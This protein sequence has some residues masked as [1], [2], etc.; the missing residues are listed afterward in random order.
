L[1]R[2]APN[3]IGIPLWVGLVSVVLWYTARVWR[4]EA[5]V[6][7]RVGTVILASVL[8]NPH[9]IIYDAAVLALPLLWF[10]A[11]MQ[12]PAQSEQATAYGRTV[13]W[14]LAALFVPTAAAIGVQASV[15]LMAW[16]FAMVSRAVLAEA[17][18]QPMDAATLSIRLAG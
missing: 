6:R 16:T 10:G 9:L 13:Y 1:T 7:V 18:H 12:E 3:W 5:S 15:L 4:S 14:L 8:V 17:T 11:F 2:L